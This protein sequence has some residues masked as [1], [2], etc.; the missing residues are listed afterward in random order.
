MFKNISAFYDYAQ[1]KLISACISCG[2]CVSQCKVMNYIPDRGNP[3]AIQSDILAFLRDTADLSDI[4][5]AKI[6]ACM[7]CYGCTDID[8]P[9]G[10]DSLTINEL[11]LR[12]LNK[13]KARLCET[14]MYAAHQK[15]IDNNTSPAERKRITTPVWKH[16]S[17]YVFFPGC[18][19]YRQPDKLLN[20]LDIM[21]AIGNAYSFL[22][23]MEYCCGMSLRGINGDADWMYSAGHNL[24]KAVEDSGARTLV[25]WCPTCACA[26][27][28]R[29][30]KYYQPAF[31]IITFGQYVLRYMDKL[32][33]R[34]DTAHTVT[35]HEPCKAAYMRVDTDSVR[36]ILS[37]IPNT[38]LIEMKHHG[39]DTMCC[40]C[41]AVD[42]RPETGS[43]V[44]G[45]RL[46]EATESGAE[47]LIDVCHNCHRLFKNYQKKKGV[48]KVSVVNYSSYIAQA[49]GI[50]REDCM[51]HSES[52]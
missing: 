47:I 1:D 41:R 11:V 5:R 31:E 42:V 35:Y 24:M 20:A 9:I 6:N 13:Q 14:D 16:G 38:A 30:K 29:I 18:N 27:E 48:S 2:K 10:V 12:K 50:V 49:M 19:V 26:V 45:D 17:E 7:K 4:A 25:L 22:P 52:E 32:C 33:F 3:S 23:G 37:A 36:A 44:T 40:G 43:L 46:K 51:D 28:H 21:D 8:C 34:N 15:Q 39:P